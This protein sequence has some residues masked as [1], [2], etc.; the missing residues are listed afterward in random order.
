MINFIGLIFLSANLHAQCSVNFFNEPIY[1][2]P[3]THQQDTQS[4]NNQSIDILFQ[5]HFNNEMQKTKLQ[6]FAIEERKVQYYIVQR[7]EDGIVYE[8]METIEANS[9]FLDVYTHTIIEND[10]VL[11]LYRIQSVCILDDG[12][13]LKFYSKAKL[14]NIN[15][16]PQAESFYDM[17][18]D[19]F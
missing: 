17:G 7:S 13:I 5:L 15:S 19:W 11:Y 3:N 14:N 10:D 8:N 9:E 12:S 6:W 18:L 2:N 4:L 1:C 16:I